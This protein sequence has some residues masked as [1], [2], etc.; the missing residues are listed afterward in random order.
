MGAVFKMLGGSNHTNGIP[1]HLGE[2]AIH[3]ASPFKLQKPELKV[4][5]V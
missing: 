4:S 2:G 3:V 5:V 1:S